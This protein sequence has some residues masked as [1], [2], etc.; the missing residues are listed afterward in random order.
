MERDRERPGE[1]TTVEVDLD[2]FSIETRPH[3][4]EFLLSGPM[5]EPSNS[6]QFKTTQKIECGQ[7]DRETGRDQYIRVSHVLFTYCS[8]TTYSRI[9]V[10]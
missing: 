9:P 5:V 6:F 8:A 1:N 3:I 4:H 10:I 7:R 2:C